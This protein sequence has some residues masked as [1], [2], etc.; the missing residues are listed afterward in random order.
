MKS[1]QQHRTSVRISVGC[2]IS[3]DG[4]GKFI[5]VYSALCSNGRWKNLEHWI[6]V[7]FI[8]GSRPVTILALLLATVM[9]QLKIVQFSRHP[10]ALPSHTLS[11]LSMYSMPT[12]SYFIL[13][14]FCWLFCV[15]L[16]FAFNRA[17]YLFDYIH[18]LFKCMAFGLRLCSVR[19]HIF[20]IV[21][22][23]VVG[24]YSK[25][26]WCGTLYTL[27]YTSERSH[28]SSYTVWVGLG[29]TNCRNFF[30]V[31]PL[32]AVEGMEYGT[33]RVP[34]IVDCSCIFI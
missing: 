17:P 30:I 12:C 19:A 10:P 18:N 6:S 27:Q 28:T 5:L 2:Q 15:A 11:R 20:S 16:E 4:N 22:M 25:A 23:L 21:G 33:S 9:V 29:T 34:Y 3:E 26:D 24:V 32:N 31:I 7:S 13:I 14:F 1:E 8:Q